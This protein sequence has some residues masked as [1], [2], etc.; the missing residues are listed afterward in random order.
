[1]HAAISRLPFSNL[2]ETN[3]VGLGPDT[4]A[5]LVSVRTLRSAVRTLSSFVI[6]KENGSNKMNCPSLRKET[7]FQRGALRN[8]PIIDWKTGENMV[9]MPLNFL[10]GLLI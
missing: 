1:M 3:F 9:Q 5:Q 4:M 10:G 6:S 7:D 2:V 8:L